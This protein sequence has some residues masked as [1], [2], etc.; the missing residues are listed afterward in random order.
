MSEIQ[1]WGEYTEDAGM[2]VELADEEWERTTCDGEV[3]DDGFIGGEEETLRGSTDDVGQDHGLYLWI[4]EDWGM[5]VGTIEDNGR[6]IGLALPSLSVMSLVLA[7]VK[8]PHKFRGHSKRRIMSAYRFPFLESVADLR[9]GV[10]S[11]GKEHN[12]D[13]SDNDS[14]RPSSTSNVSLGWTCSH[15]QQHHQLHE[16]KLLKFLLLHV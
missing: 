9:S 6:W 13:E 15:F 12:I 8:S 2:I 10:T 7:D 14:S 16:S 4:E 5:N 11:Q 3:V 1:T